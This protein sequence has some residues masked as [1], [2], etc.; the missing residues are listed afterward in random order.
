MKFHTD[1]DNG[2]STGADYLNWRN[3]PNE[4]PVYALAV[5]WKLRKNA[6]LV[7]VIGVGGS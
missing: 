6:E 7:V 1:L 2:T 5:A 4:L 3:L